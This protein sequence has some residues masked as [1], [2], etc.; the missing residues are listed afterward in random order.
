MAITTEENPLPIDS[1]HIVDD[2]SANPNN[3]NNHGWQKV[4]YAKRQRKVRPKPS[5]SGKLVNGSAVSDGDSVFRSL[6]KQSEERRRRID[7]QKAAISAAYEAPVRSVNR[8]D[9]DDSDVE[10]GGGE[11]N[12]NVAEKKTKTKKPKK[13]KVTIA[14]AAA[15]IDAGD[16]DAFL[17]DVSVSYES[18]E[19]IQL[20][21]FADY[22]GRAFSAVSA[23]QFPW[24]KL[25]RESPVAKIADIP[26]SHISEAV[27]KTSIDWISQRSHEALGS[28]VLWSLD[29]I[30]ADFASQQAG[31]KGSKKGVQQTTSKSQVA[32]FLALA[33]VLRRKPD[34]LVNLLPTLKENLKYQGQDK[35]PLIVWTVAQA[36]QGELAIGLYL[37][38]HYILP[39]LGGKSGS[40]P[41]ARDLVLQSVE[42]ILS[43][44]KAHTILVNGAV[45][46]GERLM[47]PWAFDVLLRVTFP[48]SS[49]RVKATERFEAIYPTLKEVALAGAPGSKAMKQVSQQML[50]YAVKATGDG[51]SALSREGA[52]VFIWCLTQH[53]DCYKHWDKVYMD[54]LEASVAILRKLSEEWKGLSV[55][56]SYHQ[57]LSETLKSFRY[58]NEKALAD[59]GEADR[60]ALLKSSDK[61]CKVLLGRL[62]R[63]CGCVMS[64]ALAVIVLGVGAAIMSPNPESWDLKKLSE[65]VQHQAF[66]LKKNLLEK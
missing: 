44:P 64:M 42:R 34:V 47:P 8:N 5:D 49:A 35:L 30:L 3:S 29:S 16:L 12:V 18:Q 62:S 23:S 19:E 13:L 10:G 46:K 63:G 36:C 50:S 7:A 1:N 20:M 52:G 48:A 40:N 4:T 57:A 22:F 61:Y 56:L 11:K 27:Y 21:R 66:Q 45:R 58:K 28:F 55:K 53:P 17:A 65:F 51:N 32:V 39:I 41:Q 9:D 14:E 59:E 33:M 15:K 6:E 60:E 26:V 43:A 38:A 2:D 31:G 54:N 24:T 37:W 25:F